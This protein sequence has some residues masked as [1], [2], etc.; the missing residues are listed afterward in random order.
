MGNNICINRIN[1][2]DIQY[3]INND[4]I[5]IN[6]L[7]SNNQECLIKNT[8]SPQE[9]INTINNIVE[10]KLNV[11]IIIYGEN[12]SDD[13]LIKKYYQLRQFGIKNIYVYIGG[14]FEWLLLQDIYGEDQ[15]PTSTICID[16]LE[17]SGDI[18]HD[19]RYI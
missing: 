4:M 1:F 19:I 9:E 2:K 18:S 11:K 14:L 10:K 6:T 16:M 8:L 13:S 7:T 15:F 12:S 5:I 17:Y 3:A